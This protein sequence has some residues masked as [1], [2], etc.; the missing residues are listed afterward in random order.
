MSWRDELQPASFR[1]VGF[2]VVDIETLFGRRNELHEY[3]LR[4]DPYAEDLGRKAREF[5]INAF[6]IGSDY[7]ADRDALVS[8]IEDDPTP[9]TLV[10]PTLGTKTVVPKE[11]RVIFKNTEG[12]IEYFQL[13]FVEAGANQYPS[14]LSD[15]SFFTDAFASLGITDFISFFSSNFNVDGLQDFLSSDAL[16]NTDSF[17]DKIMSILDVGDS[18][19]TGFTDLISSL[20]EFENDAIN[21][22]TSPDTLGESITGIIS[23]LS[24]VYPDSPE[25]VIAAQKRLT[26]FGDDFKSVPLTTPSR[27]QQAVNQVQMV[28]LVKNSAMAEM[29]RATSI[30]SFPSRQEA[31]RIRDDVDSYVRPQLVTLADRGEDQPYLALSKVRVGMIKDINTRAATLKNIKYIHT[32]DS[33]PALVLAYAHYEDSTQDEEII[34]RNAIRNPVFVPGD[35]NIEVLV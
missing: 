7:F 4:D 1:G 24:S 32:A 5:T 14:S 27:I 34:K 25:Q 20:N 26:T 28:S 13:T 35:S 6:V 22:L 3:P 29:M 19:G 18:S 23:Q 11:C 2:G 9:G 30:I 16:S 10:H 8:A 33:V 17:I 15:T 21:Q 31:L 12:G